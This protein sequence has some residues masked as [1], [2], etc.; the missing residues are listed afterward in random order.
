M[1]SD[2]PGILV[3]GPE[4]GRR[5]WQPSPANGSVD[6]RVTP[7]DVALRTPYSF[8]EQCIPPGSRV[9]EH[10]H[11]DHDEFLHFLA[12]SGVAI[13]DG[14]EH[15]IVPGTTIVVGANRRHSFVNTGEAD[16]RWL[17]FIQPN[18]L[19]IYFAEVGIPVTPGE[20]APEP[21]RRRPETPYADVFAPREARAK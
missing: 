9:P 17:W 10:A 2:R 7:E 13:L 19:E 20:S 11:P 12:G 8:G 15:T 14:E 18:G 16:L 3:V 5:L 4:G 6:I 21:F 1:T